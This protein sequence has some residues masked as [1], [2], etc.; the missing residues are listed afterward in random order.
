MFQDPFDSKNLMPSMVSQ[1]RQAQECPTDQRCIDLMIAAIG[2]ML[3][4]GPRITKKFLLFK[5][6]F[7]ST[8]Y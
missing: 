2:K 4:V 1:L 6:N 7:H 8:K 5:F 3:L